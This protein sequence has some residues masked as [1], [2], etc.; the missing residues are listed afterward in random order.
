MLKATH[1]ILCGVVMQT[2]MAG[3]NMQGELEKD[4]CLGVKV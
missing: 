1:F 4:K 2:E 3:E